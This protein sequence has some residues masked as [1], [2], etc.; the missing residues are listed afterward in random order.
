MQ[1]G[2][3]AREDKNTSRK[4]YWCACEAMITFKR[5]HDGKYFIQYHLIKSNKVNE[6][7]N[8]TLFTCHAASIGTSLVV[9]IHRKYLLCYFII[10]LS[11]QTAIQLGNFKLWKKIICPFA[12][13]RCNNNVKILF[14]KYN[15]QINNCKKRKGF[16]TPW[17]IK[18]YTAG[19]TGKDTRIKN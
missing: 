3:K 13:V 16:D 8:T 10:R 5:M 2:F 1:K 18:N 7:A 9:I 12:E 14:A 11:I 15:D 17:T 19:Q 6:E 4:H